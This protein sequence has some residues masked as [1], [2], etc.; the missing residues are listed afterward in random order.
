MNVWRSP[1]S[2]CPDQRIEIALVC[3]GD[4]YRS[5]CSLARY[6]RETIT[7]EKFLQVYESEK[8][9]AAQ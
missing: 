1:L 7:V 8:E 3:D 2:I 9:K 6:A 5:G 4:L